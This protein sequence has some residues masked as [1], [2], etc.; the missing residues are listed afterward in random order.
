MSVIYDA[1]ERGYK[2]NKIVCD[3]GSEFLGVFKKLCNDQ[4]IN[5]EYVQPG[6][7]NKVAPIESLNRTLRGMLERY[8][9]INNMNATNIFNTIRKI[10][11]LFTIHITQH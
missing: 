11:N 8:R 1:K 7:K 10:N 5:I 6:D 3:N 2:I 9:I 4:N